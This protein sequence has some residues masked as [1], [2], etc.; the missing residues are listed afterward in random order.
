M[1]SAGDAPR[2][3]ALHSIRIGK[4]ASARKP[5]F[6]RAYQSAPVA[7]LAWIGTDALALVPLGAVR[8]EWVAL[9]LSIAPG[10]LAALRIDA[11][12]SRT[13]PSSNRIG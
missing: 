12:R 4:G 2:F 1:S 13:L 3:N 5:L 11:R 6:R 10:P 8:C 7:E 9:H